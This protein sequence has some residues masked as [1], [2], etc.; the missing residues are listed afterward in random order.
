MIDTRVGKIIKNNN[1]TEYK[2]ISVCKND[3]ER[4]LLHG[5]YDFVVINDL[6]CFEE[7]GSW[8]GGKYFPCFSDEDST[9][10]LF[11]ALKYLNYGN[12]EDDNK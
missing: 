1:G 3:K 8:S 6:S 7:V 9:Y 11:S 12:I 2:V 5:G 4:A 10:T